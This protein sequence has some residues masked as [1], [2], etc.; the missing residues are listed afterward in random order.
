MMTMKMKVH[1]NESGML[2]ETR[3]TALK[4]MNETMRCTKNCLTNM[5]PHG[6][7]QDLEYG[8]VVFVQSYEDPP[9]LSAF[10]KP[11]TKKRKE[12][13]TEALA[14]AAVAPAMSGGN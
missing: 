4:K 11:E 10:K 14:G 12:L 6:T 7:R 8:L 9:D 13:L 5:D 1:I 2:K 3:S